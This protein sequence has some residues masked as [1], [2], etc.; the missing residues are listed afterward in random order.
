MNAAV[1]STTRAAPAASARRIEAI[2][3]RPPPYWTGTRARARSARGGGGWP[4]RPRGRRRG[5][6]RAGSARPPPTNERA[7]SSG[8]S[9]YTVSSS[10]RPWRSRTALPS[11]MSTAGSRIMRRGPGRRSSAAGA[12]RAGPDFS[13]WDWRPY[14]G[15]RRHHAH[16]LAAVVG[17]A[18]HVVHVRGPRGEGVRVVEGA[19]VGQARHELARAPPGHGVPADLRHLEPV[20]L[21]VDHGPLEQADALGA[22]ALGRRL[23]QQ[24]HAQ[25]EPEQRHAGR[26]PLAQQLVEPE[27]AYLLHRLRQRPHAGQHHAVGLA[28]ARVVAGQLRPRAHVL[29]R[30]R[31][32]SAGCPC[33]SRGSRSASQEAL[34][35]G[36]ALLARVARPRPARSARANALN[37]A[38]TMWWAFVPAST[39]RWSVSLAVFATARK[40]SSA[41]SVSKSPTRAGRK[42]GLEGREGPARDVDRAAR[43]RLVHRHHGVAEARIPARSPSASSSAWPSARPVSSTVWCGPVS[44]SPS[45]RTSRSKPAVAREGVEQVVEEADP[46]RSARPP[47]SPSRASAQLDVGLAGRAADVRGAAHARRSIDSACTGKPSA[48]ASAAPAGARRAAASPGKD[49]RAIRR[50]KVAGESADWK[51]AAPP[52]GSTWLEPAT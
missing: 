46:G 26:H 19:R 31:R 29:E 13:G 45:T 50:R 5:P 18:E 43:A 7:A 20:R 21:E 27:P 24:L 49:T 38:S 37:A 32:P 41:R 42:I 17:R 10:K 25:A 39:R 9:A 4:A 22:A 6:P 8:S 12:A 51:R 48:R 23:E 44:R 2:E 11:R 47:P 52:V 30:L 16:E 40:N 15:A 14:T 36:H 1:P 34:G 28:H 35:R 33:R 3:R